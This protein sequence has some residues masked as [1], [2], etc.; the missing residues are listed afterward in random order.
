M[1]TTGYILA[2]DSGG[3]KTVSLLVRADG[4]VVAAA[5]GRGAAATADLPGDALEALRPV[6]TEVLRALPANGQLLGAYAC[7]GGLN[8]ATVKAALQQLSGIAAVEVGRESSGDVVFSGAPYWGFDI[9]VMAGTGSIALG[10]NAAGE[11]RVCGGWGAL[12]DDR[13]SG[14]DVGRQ[15][16]QALAEALDYRG[17]ATLLLPAIGRQPPFTESLPQ[18]S[19]LDQAPADLTYAQRLAI[20]EAIKRAYP[21]LDRGTVAGLFPVVTDC[22]RRGDALAIGILRGAA[23]ALAAMVCA[24]AD[25]LRLSQPRVVALGGV[26]ASGEPLLSW[27]AEAVQGSC[28]GAALPRSDFSLIRGAVVVALRRAGL[29]VNAA[30]VETVRLTAARFGA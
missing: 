30:L 7:L 1:S 9:A 25:E 3:S 2:L 10:V 15:A 23:A 13:G 18:D 24:L 6:V 16:L 28:P 11:Q 19:V 4:T 29:P 14:Y 22:A 5:R 26:F 12:I 17:R 27:F 20:K 8:T 21:R